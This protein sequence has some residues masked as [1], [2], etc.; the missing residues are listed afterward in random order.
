VI[1][2]LRA[3][4]ERLYNLEELL[5]LCQKYLGFDPGEVGG[6][7]AKASF[8]RSLVEYCDRV[9]A[10]EAL[11]EAALAGKLDQSSG[12]REIRDN[13]VRADEEL[14]L[15]DLLGD[16]LVARKIGEGRIGHVYEVRREGREYRLKVLKA[17]A[18]R[19]ARGLHRFFALNR[20]VAEVD[21]WGL[22]AGLTVGTIEDR[23][24]ILH[25]F[26]EGQPLAARIAR[27][28]PIH[29]NEARPLLRG[30]LEPLE[31]LHNRGLSHANLHLGNVLVAR[32]NEGATKVV[33]LDAGSNRLRMRARLGTF[34][35]TE[36]PGVVASPATVAPEQLRGLPGDARSDVYSFG[37]LLYEVL[38]GKPPFGDGSA[39]DALVGHL[40]SEPRPPSSVAPRGWVS[41]QLDE[42]VL[43]LLVKDPAERPA[44]A[45]ALLYELDNLGRGAAAGAEVRITEADLEQMVDQLVRDPENADTALRLESA[46]DQGV[47]PVWVAGAFGIAAESLETWGDP[48]RVE[49]KKNLLMR[50]ARL[51]EGARNM[52]RAEQIYMAMLATD[53]T[54][55]GAQT[56]L[57]SVKRKLHKHEDLIEML[58]KRTEEAPTGIE[59]GQAYAD[60]G[61]IYLEDLDDRDQALVAFAQAYCEQ[62]QNNKYAEDIE[63]LAGTI[64]SK[65]EEVLSACLGV[66]NDDATPPESKL[67]IFN[68]MGRWYNLRVARPDLALGVYQAAL[69]IDP[70]NNQALDGMCQ[71][72][73][74]AQQW[75]ELGTALLRWADAATPAVARDLRCEAAEI[76]D[77]QLGDLGRARNL[78]EQILEDDPGHDKASDALVRLYEKAGDFAGY[79]KILERRGDSESGEARLKTMCRVAEAYGEHLNDVE[80]AIRRFAVVLSVDE[81]YADAL[82]GLGRVYE[83]S[84]RFQELIENLYTQIR[85]ATT[86]RQKISLWEKAA[87][88]Y[89]EEFLD[90]GKAAVAWEAILDIDGGYESALTTLPRHYR[91]LDRW[92]DLV[93]LYDRHI[94]L[95]TDDKT[96]LELTLAQARV[97][98]E[99]LNAQDRAMQAYEFAL[100]IDPEHAGALE[101]LGRLREWA[102]D[103]HAAVDVFEALADK[104]TT[105]AARAEQYL[106]AA[107]LLESQGDIDAAIE[108]YK[109]A[110]DAVPTDSSTAMALRAAYVTRGD[111]NAAIQLLEREFE[112]TEGEVAK[113]RYASEVGMLCRDRL[114]DDDRASEAAK[115]AL[116]FDPTNLDALRV[117]GEIAFESGR[118]LEAA[119]HYE[120]LA[121]RADILPKEIA[122]VILVRYVDALTKTGSTEKALVPMDTLL[123]LAPDNAAALERVAQVTFEHG[124]PKRAV[125]L[126]QDLFL[127]FGDELANH[128]D[129]LYRYGESL[130]RTGNLDA[131]IQ[132]LEEAADLDPTA[133]DPLTALAKAYEEA[134]HWERAVRT[135]TRHLDI[136]DEDERVQLLMEIGDIVS[137]KLHDLARAASCFVAALDERPDDRRLLT[138]LMQIYSESQDWEKLVDVVVRLAD[139]VDDPQQKAKYLF[140]AGMVS[141]RQMGDNE[142]G[143]E[144]FH[145]VVEIDPENY[146]AIAEAAALERQAGR[147]DQV[148]ELF[149]GK[150]ERATE[151]GDKEL[152]V[153]T[154]E[155]L[156]ALYE[157]DMY[158]AEQA[159]DAYEAAQTLDPNNRDRAMKLTELYLQDAERYLEKAVDTQL[160]VLEEDF[161]N[162]LAYKVMR[163]LYTETKQADSAWCMCQAMSVL[164][165]AEPD[166]ER[167][168]KRLRAETAAPARQ[169]LTDEDWLLRL[170]HEDTDPLLTSVFAL[171]EPAVIGKRGQ[172]LDKLGYDEHYRLDLANHPYPMCQTLHYAA[173]VLGMEAPPAYHNPNDQAGLSFLHSYTPG[174]ILGKAAMARE[175][176][177]QAAA[178]IAARHLAYYRPGM[179]V[180]HLVPTGTGLKAWLFAAIK[181]ISPQFPVG[182]E[183]EGPVKEALSALDVGIVGPARDHL[184]TIV[185][186]LMQS[187]GALD[188]K[189]WV[190]GVDLTADRAGFLVAHDMETAVEIIQ[191]SEEGAAALSAQ[192]RFR[193]LVLFGIGRPFFELRRGL[194]IAVDS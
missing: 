180:R 128:G 129:S 53:P 39:M 96:R 118:F 74:K 58:L 73:R 52:E 130:R 158:L 92:E 189:K 28:G 59:R 5:E 89:D 163:R 174:I 183:L 116:N 120:Q 107:R 170:M 122:T 68:R 82:R 72:Y 102:G 80:E 124:A 70:V 133:R 182:S 65:W 21:H 112:R 146:K 194:G 185:T 22:P 17:E 123:R 63:K 42:F 106:R 87:H 168:Y 177:S 161:Y 62:P 148:E 143:L 33:L 90:H 187:G 6:A 188:L 76:L 175:V 97:L 111:I 154:F 169:A 51:Y 191:A 54:D 157:K 153:E 66:T 11:C 88:V 121:D 1:E 147:H 167:F 152:M 142:R 184:A 145:N 36:L 41:R 69:G 29:F 155:E 150:L 110:L 32:T 12:L 86:P 181:L 115:R 114:H 79:V 57:E 20:M 27:T 162:Q 119:R 64:H 140:T 26:F 144:F 56:A 160:A 105:P 35:A 61:K 94:R 34:G 136:A 77:V 44:D 127:N 192:E 190:Q 137:G 16:F 131:A 81:T 93:E 126:Y 108:H 132:R 103:A 67:L 48:A 50:S 165:V 83:K 46:V 23:F 31:E 25:E 109:R 8:V 45:S 172:S 40:A 171:I 156:G 13:G 91:V 71:I 85:L 84:G 60:I 7:T 19:D 9:D 101:A 98:S 38:S 55:R 10:V 166:E 141:A 134:G 117:L 15:G 14:P 100:T 47:D 24:C 151:A 193:H 43:R 173:G 176:P 186:K 139:F 113:A 4:L 125:E 99:Q 149:R 78:Y 135:K 3:E 49:A 75:P 37:A 159:V 178:F 18:V 138:K 30:V 164:R 104:A 95:V 2:T 179:Y